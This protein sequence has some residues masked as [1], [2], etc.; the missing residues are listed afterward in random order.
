MN[1][2]LVNHYAIP[3]TLAGGTRHF[4]LAKELIKRGHDVTVIACKHHHLANEGLDAYQPYQIYEF[5]RVKFFWI[6]A[7][8][9]S[10]HSIDRLVNVLVFALRFYLETSLHKL[11]RPDAILGS[12]V[13]LFT[14]LA[15]ERVAR[16]HKIPF[17]L[18]IRDLWPQGLIEL[19]HLSPKHP[20]TKVFLIIEKYLYRH[21]DSI[22]SVL[23]GAKEHIVAKGGDSSKVTWISNGADF[24]IIP[25]AMP[26]T[27]KSIFTVMYAG[28]HGEGNALSPIL[29]AAEILK[30]QSWENRVRFRFI[31]SGVQKSHLQEIAKAKQLNNVSF[32]DPIPKAQIYEALSDADAFVLS[33][34][35]SPLYRWGIS[36]N[37]LFDYLAMARPIIHA[38]ETSYDPVAQARAGISVP[39]EDAMAIAE[40][41]KILIDM[42]PQARWEMGLRG[43]QYVAD[44]FDLRKLAIKLEKI[45]Y[46]LV[47]P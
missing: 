13:H 35:K 7:P 1:I 43:R 8:K 23:S 14:P 22:V 29:E 3:P 19:G 12:S 6:P 21:A 10:T 41:I 9:Y 45:F 15:A 38:V 42:S 11:P 31:G 46:E 26:P 2:W 34:H 5:D 16:R 25:E 47:E 39:A 30:H 20:L 40:A 36:A 32:E 28:S 4:S 27:P 18:E 33:W 24:S 44:E 17:V 37:K